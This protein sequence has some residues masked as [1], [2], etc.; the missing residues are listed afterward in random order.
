[1]QSGILHI[2]GKRC[3]LLLLLGAGVAVFSS[4]QTSA[5]NDNTRTRILFLLDASGSMQSKWGTGN[6]ETR[7][8]SARNILTE[9]VDYLSQKKDVELALRVYGHQSMLALKDCK[10]TQLEVGFGLN[11][12][13]YIKSRL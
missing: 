9:M 8:H 4:A 13:S 11:S 6:T 7:W 10:D 2:M 3:F 5:P 12:T 1:M